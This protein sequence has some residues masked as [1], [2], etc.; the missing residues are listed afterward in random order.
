M[1]FRVL[2]QQG[3]ALMHAVKD[4]QITNQ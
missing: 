1:D 2:K 3:K 4:G